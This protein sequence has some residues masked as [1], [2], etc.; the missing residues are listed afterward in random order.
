[1]TDHPAA[2][3]PLEVELELPVRTYDVDFAGVVSNIVYIRWLEDLRLTLLEEHLPLKEQW[4]QDVVPVL[5]STQIEYRRPI[6]LF[7]A[8]VGRMWM[9][10]AGRVKWTVRAEILL[11]GQPAAIAS[12]TGAFVS[13]STLRPVALPEELA[14]KFRQQRCRE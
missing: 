3:R 7:D 2:S 13:L 6:R 14:A 4:E 1:M 10:E 5:A 11:D 9:S 8:P 12:Q